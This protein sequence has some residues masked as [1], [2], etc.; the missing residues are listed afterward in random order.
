MGGDAFPAHKENLFG[1]DEKNSEPKA[2]LK[3]SDTDK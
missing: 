3:D 1:E 2:T